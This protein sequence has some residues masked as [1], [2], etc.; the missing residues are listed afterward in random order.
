MIFS[1]IIILLVGIVAYFHYLQ[2]LFSSTLSLVFAVVA[3]ALA[4]G[5]HEKVISSL[6]AGR[7]ADQAS[8]MVVCGLFAGIYLILRIISDKVVSGA[9]LVPVLAD[10]V[11]G[12]VIGVVVGLIAGGIVAFAA[13]TMPFGAAIGGYSRLPMNDERSV[14]IPPAAGRSQSRDAM[15]YDELTAE[16]LAAAQTGMFVPADDFLIGLVSTMSSGSLSTDTPLSAIHPDWLLELFGQR[17]GVE[18]GGKHTAV[19]SDKGQQVKVDATL[20]L[21]QGIAQRDGEIKDLRPMTL[22]KIRRPEAGKIFVVVPTTWTK[23]AADGDWLVRFSAGGVRLVANG[24]N[25]FPLGTVE[26]S[27]QL[28]VAKPDDYLFASAKTRD[29]RIAFLFEVDPTDLLAAGTAAVRDGVLFEGKRLARVDL[30]G[31]VA[32]PKSSVNVQDDVLRKTSAAG[33]P[34]P[35]SATPAAAPVPTPTPAPTPA[36]AEQGRDVMPVP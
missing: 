34:A 9:V 10:R 11:G 33:A 28:V 25:H 4:M 32:E 13:Q 16:N 1:I 7:Y 5:W 24:K 22:D 26:A 36:P 15:V 30:S 6:L 20:T 27:G 29:A 2:G 31:K 18:P 17:I 35:A 23:E 14:V 19:N 3:A 21:L 8:A 12:G